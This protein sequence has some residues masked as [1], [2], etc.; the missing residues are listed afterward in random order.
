MIGDKS[1]TD[2]G[3]LILIKDELGDCHTLQ[4]TEGSQQQDA[5]S[6]GRILGMLRVL[7]QQ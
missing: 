7:V 1:Y 4:R 2:K 3:G 5:A 6:K